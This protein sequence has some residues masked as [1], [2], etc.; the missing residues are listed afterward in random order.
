MNRK[1][2]KKLLLVDDEE[3]FVAAMEK[4]LT[5]MNAKIPVPLRAR[6]SL[7]SSV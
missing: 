1:Y 3:A 2:L 7:R 4:R 6:R 5:I